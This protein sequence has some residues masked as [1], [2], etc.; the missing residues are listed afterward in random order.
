MADTS[1]SGKLDF[2][3]LMHALKNDANS[4]NCSSC[5]PCLFESWQ[6]CCKACRRSHNAI[7]TDMLLEHAKK[8]IGLDAISFPYQTAIYLKIICTKM[9]PY[10]TTIK[11]GAFF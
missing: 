7:A 2:S 8:V 10:Q 6:L 11:A 3:E 5:A 4:N 9:G 1:H